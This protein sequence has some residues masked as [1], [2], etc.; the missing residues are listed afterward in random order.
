MPVF[1]GFA[2]YGGPA[3]GIQR[4]IRK[5]RAPPGARLTNFINLLK[6]LA[7]GELEAAAGLGA[8][9]FLALDHP[10]ITGQEAALLEHRPQ[11]GF[12]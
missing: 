12:V 4:F 6:R 1:P 8:A 11:V 3:C 10:R 5:N 7:L 9:V 2:K